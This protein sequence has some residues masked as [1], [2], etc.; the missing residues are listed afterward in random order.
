M[1]DDAALASWIVDLVDAGRDCR[2]KLQA[3]SGVVR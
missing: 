3:V 1:A 2:S